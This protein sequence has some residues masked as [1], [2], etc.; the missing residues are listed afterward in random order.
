LLPDYL[1]YDVGATNCS[2]DIC[3]DFVREFKAVGISTILYH[4]GAWQRN[5]YGRKYYL[6]GVG[7]GA[8]L[9]PYQSAENHFY[10]KKRLQ[11]LTALNPD[12][13]WFD[14]PQYYQNMPNTTISELYYAVKAQNPN[15]PYI[16]NCAGD[17]HNLN[18]T[19]FPMD[20]ASLEE[21]LLPNAGQVDHAWWTKQMTFGGITYP[22]VKEISASTRTNYKWYYKYP[23]PEPLRTLASIQASYNKAKAIGVPIALS[24]NPKLDGVLDQDQVD[25]INSIVL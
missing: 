21:N 2:N 10:L 6:E 20:G 24:V 11:E 13:I 25:L 22:C 14:I 16:I 18:N 8:P 7:F 3:R 4:I 15:M 17:I 5:W 23:S 1:K 12:A 9:Y 19:F